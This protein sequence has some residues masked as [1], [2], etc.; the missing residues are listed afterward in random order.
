MMVA[1]EAWADPEDRGLE[2]TEAGGEEEDGRHCITTTGLGFLRSRACR[3]KR[4][5]K[6]GLVALCAGIAFLHCT[7]CICFAVLEAGWEVAAYSF[8]R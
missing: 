6:K 1:A 5:V 3:K 8:W 2:D 4:E 7:L